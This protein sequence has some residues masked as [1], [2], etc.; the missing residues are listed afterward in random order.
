M[1]HTHKVLRNR[2]LQCD[3]CW[4]VRN[5]PLC[6]VCVV[7]TLGDDFLRLRYDGVD[8][9]ASFEAIEAQRIARHRYKDGDTRDLVELL[10]P[11]DR[12]QS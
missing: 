12:N 11:N 6:P 7:P 10:T 2:H 4:Q 8:A 9:V 5:E 1:S 3:T